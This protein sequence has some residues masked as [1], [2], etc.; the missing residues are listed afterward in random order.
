MGLRVQFK[1]ETQNFFYDNEATVKVSAVFVLVES[2][3]SHSFVDGLDVLFL[4]VCT[5]E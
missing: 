4:C 5:C 3:N 1:G 2:F